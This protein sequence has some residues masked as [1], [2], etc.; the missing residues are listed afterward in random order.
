M[1]DPGDLSDI[2]A[3]ECTPDE[4]FIAVAVQR[5]IVQVWDAEK[6]REAMPRFDLDWRRGRAE[7]G[8]RESMPRRLAMRSRAALVPSA[9]GNGPVLT[10]VASELTH[11]LDVAPDA[12]AWARRAR[13]FSW[14]RAFFDAYL[15]A[16]EA[17]RL[18]ESERER[19]EYLRLRATVLDR[20]ECADE[21]RTDCE[22][23][24]ELEAE[25]DR[26]ANDEAALPRDAEASGG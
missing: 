13:H 3:V 19:A 4:R 8:G 2:L 18:A 21:A 14:H 7:T 25:L 12:A 10:R 9:I 22:H 11:P 23:A 24:T 1:E 20:L 5:S 17:I 15:D 6:L 16:S 26:E